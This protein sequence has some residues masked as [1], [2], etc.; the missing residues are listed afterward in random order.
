MV[1]MEATLVGVLRESPVNRDEV[2]AEGLPGVPGV[3]G[4][5]GAG[6]VLLPDSLKVT[7]PTDP[8]GGVTSWKSSVDP[9]MLTEV[10]NNVPL[11]R[12]VTYFPVLTERRATVLD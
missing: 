5:P 6:I 7:A 3:P 10:G 4:A 2:E 1:W 11:T 8:P 12:T 9:V